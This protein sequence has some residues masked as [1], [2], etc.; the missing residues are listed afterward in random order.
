MT[1][2]EAAL[3][4]AGSPVR[5]YRAGAGPDLVLLHGEP[6]PARPTWEPVWPAAIQHAHVVAPDLPGFGGTPSGPTGRTLSGYRSWLL[7]FLD[8]CGLAGATVA[9]LGLGFEIAQGVPAPLRLA[10]PADILRY[11]GPEA[12]AGPARPA[13][14]G[15]AW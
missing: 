14:T 10:S 8:A 6:G 9:G 7:M 15:P 2:D 1:H 12:T 11:V 4:V 5:L 3:T 13:T